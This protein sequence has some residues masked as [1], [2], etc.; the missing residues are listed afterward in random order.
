MQ[1]SQYDPSEPGS[2]E[3]GSEPARLRPP[4]PS[5]DSCFYLLFFIPAPSRLGEPGQATGPTGERS[6]LAGLGP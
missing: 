5:R 2:S 6:R 4:E 3:P 1:T